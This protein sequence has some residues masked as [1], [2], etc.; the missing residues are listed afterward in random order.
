[1]VSEGATQVKVGTENTYRKCF[2]NKKN[3]L[4]AVSAHTEIASL[5]QPVFTL[6]RKS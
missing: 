1:M 3:T 4:L 2:V 5:R 6:R